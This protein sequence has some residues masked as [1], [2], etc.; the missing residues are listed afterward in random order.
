MIKYFIQMFERWK[1]SVAPMEPECHI[2]A[3]ASGNA[4]RSDRPCDR[5]QFPLRNTLAIDMEG[6][7]FYRTVADFPDILALLVKGVSDYAD[8]NKD[9]SYHRYASAISAMYMLAF[10]QEYVT[11]ERI[12][13]I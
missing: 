3:I 4:V 13:R 6:A 12:P 10:I 7:A 1:S 2:G 11:S 8:S 9:D 5:I